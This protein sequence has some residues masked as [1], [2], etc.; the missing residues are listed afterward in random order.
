MTHPDLDDSVLMAYADG[1][2]DSQTMVLVEAAMEA[3]SEIAAR[4]AFFAES[5][6]LLRKAFAQMEEP[7][8]PA[9]LERQIRRQAWIVRSRRAIQ[10][11]I[12]LAAAIA[13]FVIGGGH[14]PGLPGQPGGAAAHVAGIVQ[15]VAEYHSVFVRETEH[16]VEV[17]AGRRAHIEAWLGERV[18]FPLHVPDLSARGLTFAGARMLAVDARPVA[19]LIYIGA[20]GARIALCVTALE[21][22]GGSE[23]RLLT[24]RGFDMYARTEG[25]FLF[26]LAAPEG[27]KQGRELVG[28][29]TSLLRRG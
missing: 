6:N 13:G 16:L 3:D 22:P 20:D 7:P 2:A 18:G 23:A 1:E 24:Q 8:I 10:F 27:S 15:E 9:V 29:L 14:L 19:Q 4:V 21:E 17:P 11:A 12:P 25:A 28:E 26:I 5:S